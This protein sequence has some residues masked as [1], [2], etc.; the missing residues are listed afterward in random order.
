MINGKIINEH[1]ISNKRFEYR[2][3]FNN[4][5]VSKYKMEDGVKAVLLS[6]FE[7]I[8]NILFSER[9]NVYHLEININDICKYTS[10]EKVSEIEEV[11]KLYIEETTKILRVMNLSPLN[12]VYLK[13]KII[14]SASK[15]EKE[16]FILLRCIRAI[17]YSLMQE[18]NYVILKKNILD[19]YYTAFTLVDVAMELLQNSFKYITSEIKYPVIHVWPFK[20]LDSIKFEV[21]NEKQD[22]KGD[23]LHRPKI[24]IYN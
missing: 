20:Y 17:T 16:D 1:R 22:D 14:A 7:G 3:E 9:P 4:I 15:L 13:K 8:K 18:I 2:K 12:W 21:I 6:C 24:Y 23:I 5:I 11:K 10:I 19:H